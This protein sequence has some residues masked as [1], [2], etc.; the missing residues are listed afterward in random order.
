MLYG[1]TQLCIARDMAKIGN[2]IDAC[3]KRHMSVTRSVLQKLVSDTLGERLEKRVFGAVLG[4]RIRAA[5]FQALL[6][7]AE[8][9]SEF[10][11]FIHVTQIERFHAGMSQ[12]LQMLRSARSLM[13]KEVEGALFP[14]R[15]YNTWS[16]AS[17]LLARHA[18]EGRAEYVDRMTFRF[19][20]ALRD[21]IHDSDK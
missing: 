3:G 2:A 11:V 7:E 4:S 14:A 13:V 6:C 18:F 15:A 12:A 1:S 20:A 16:S 5:Q 8:L 10:R 19:P 17:H 9:G 21:A